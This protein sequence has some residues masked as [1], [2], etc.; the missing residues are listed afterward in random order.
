MDDPGPEI[1]FVDVVVGDALTLRADLL[2]LPATASGTLGEPWHSYLTRLGVS[3]PVD[4][5]SLGRLVMVPVH[6]GSS[7]RNVA[8]AATVGAGG[9]PAEPQVIV[10]IA[11]QLGQATR[12]DGFDVV[13]TPVLGSGVGRL[14]PEAALGGLVDGFIRTAAPGARLRVVARSETEQVVLDGW[15]EKLLVDALMA[16]LGAEVSSE[17]IAEL[18]ASSVGHGAEPDSSSAPDPKPGFAAHP[19]APPPPSS[20]SAEE[21]NGPPSWAGPNDPSSAAPSIPSSSAEPNSAPSSAAE[22]DSPPSSSA[23]PS[24]PPPVAVVDETSTGRTRLVHDQPASADQLGRASLAAEVASLLRELAASD[25]RSDEAFAVHLDAPWGAGKSSLVGF[26][27]QEL[28]VPEGDDPGWTVITLDAWRSSQLSPAWWALLGHLRS[29]VRESMDRRGRIRFSW[30]R[31]V[32]A[33]RRLWRIWLPPAIV[34]VILLVL[35]LVQGDVGP[36]MTVLTGVV[37]FTVAIGGLLGKFFSLDSLQGARVHERLNE[38]PMEEVSEQIWAVRQQSPK[39]VLLV[40][41]D[42]DRCNERFAVELLDA[43]QTLLRKGPERPRRRAPQQKRMPALVVLAV[44][45]GRWLRAAY[46]D[47]YKVF[48]PYVSEPGRPLG[49]LFLDK[50]FQLR[51]ELPTLNRTQVKGYL[52]GLL[53]VTPP[54][55][56]ADLD[57]LLDRIAKAPSE[58]GADSLDERMTDLMGEARGVDEVQ[59]Q[60]VA[61]KVLETRR[62]DPERRQRERHILE[63]FA[64]LLEPNPRATKR[65]LMAYNVA[66]AARLCELDPPEPKTLALWTVVTTR[67]PALAEWVRG[68]LPDGDLALVDA[69]GHPSGLLRDPEVRVVVGSDKGGPLDLERVMRCCGYQPPATGPG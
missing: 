38:N 11:E 40:L 44:G 43:V 64:E 56:T 24:A 17:Q 3:L 69:P 37:A 32:T 50:L 22:P 35:W 34:V 36:T 60:Q 68:E 12:D 27:G 26:I 15:L 46:E 4:G 63:E 9:E 66:F 10:Q 23:E 6:R 39:N 21:P 1:P 55:P 59:R 45:D 51:I 41:D 13:V 25:D 58:V 49:H 19:I 2:V 7:A 5:A 53:N 18:A 52:S 48:S 14:E 28:S 30:R 47:A 16:R 20:S 57:D 67:W 61:A 65:F 54:H 42:L 29:G 33:A 31:F 62:N 8:V